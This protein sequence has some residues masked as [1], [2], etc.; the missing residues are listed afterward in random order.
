MTPPPQPHRTFYDLTLL[1]GWQFLKLVYMYRVRVSTLLMTDS[2]LNRKA[3]HDMFAW[4][5]SPYRT[6]PQYPDEPECDNEINKTSSDLP[7]SMRF[8]QL[9][10]SVKDHVGVYR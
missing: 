5:A 8:R 3:S 4:L 1:Q 10:N 9:K 6:L 7:L 2:L